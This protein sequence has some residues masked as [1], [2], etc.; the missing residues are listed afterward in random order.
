[1]SRSHMAGI[2]PTNHSI[3]DAH[4]LCQ[5]NE[6]SF[7]DMALYL[8]VAQMP[9]G[10]NL[11]IFVMRTDDR[12]QIKLIPLSHVH[13]WGDYNSLL[14][15]AYRSFG[16]ISALKNFRMHSGIRKLNTRNKLCFTA[17]YL[18]WEK[19]H[20]HM[21]LC[22]VYAIAI[23]KVL[24]HV[25]TTTWLE[26]AMFILTCQRMVFLAPCHCQFHHKRLL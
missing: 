21:C 12:Q 10:D 20:M 16:K 25:A 3:W 17:K 15:S 11:G 5:M 24:S 23:K 8:W 14:V 9:R 7:A 2:W 6:A 13:V 4:G 1:M 26:S 19:S 18:Q 22:P